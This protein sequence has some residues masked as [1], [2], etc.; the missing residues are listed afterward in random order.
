MT[1]CRCESGSR[2]IR[3]DKILAGLLEPHE[4]IVA[5]ERPKLTW[6]TVEIPSRTGMD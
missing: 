1:P 4:A 5:G 3:G 6:R 2:P